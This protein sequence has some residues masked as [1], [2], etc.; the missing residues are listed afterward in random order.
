MTIQA[1]QSA[2]GL[3]D[4]S[5]MPVAMIF[6]TLAEKYHAAII[7][8]RQEEKVAEIQEVDMDGTAMTQQQIMTETLAEPSQ[9]LDANQPTAMASHNKGTCTC[10][11]TCLC[12]PLCSLDVGEP[13]QCV[14]NPGFYH[15]EAALAGVDASNKKGTTQQPVPP[16]ECKPKSSRAVKHHSMIPG[17]SS[18]LDF[19]DVVFS[20]KDKITAARLRQ[21]SSGKPKIV[22][23]HTAQD[24]ICLASPK[25]RQAVVKRDRKASNGK[26]KHTELKIS[27]AVLEKL[28]NNGFAMKG[29]Q[30]TVKQNE[31]RD[32]PIRSKPK[33][34]K[35]ALKIDVPTTA[36]AP[37]HDLYNTMAPG[38]PLADVGIGF[39]H[40][41]I[42]GPSANYQGPNDNF[43][44]SI[45]Y[46]QTFDHNGAFNGYAQGGQYIDPSL[47]TQAVPQIPDMSMWANAGYYLPTNMVHGAGAGGLPAG[48]NEDGAT[49]DVNMANSDVTFAPAFSWM[50]EFG[51]HENELNPGVNFM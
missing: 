48:W 35:E 32:I 51:Y 3:Q 10:P 16:I 7:A 50:S 42:A 34:T 29:K 9:A 33:P 6:G 45:G 28:E 19:D 5:K 38:M 13:C 30:S 37:T 23:G 40:M 31:N 46:G 18:L 24:P 27:P 8:G 14:V 2:G 26:S 22:Q 25:G 20:K 39:E 21:V 43:N 44:N 41:H 47:I 4:V 49:N 12:K 11:S 1:M 36:A 15:P 17:Y